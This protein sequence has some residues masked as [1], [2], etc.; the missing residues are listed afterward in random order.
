MKVT[1]KTDGVH[2]SLYNYD[3]TIHIEYSPGSYDPVARVIE[4]PKVWREDGKQYRVTMCD[5]N[6]NGNSD[7][8]VTIR[9]PCGVNA[10]GFSCNSTIEIY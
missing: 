8:Y 7:D 4:F 10:F 1:P 3:M 5:Y 2:T 6:H 9:V